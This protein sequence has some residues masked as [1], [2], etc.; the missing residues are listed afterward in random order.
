MKKTLFALALGC[1][2]MLVAKDIPVGLKNAKIGAPTLPGWILNRSGKAADYGKGEIIAGSKA[3]EK[4]FKITAPANLRA[5]FYTASP[6]SVKVGQVL[7]ISAKAKGKGTIIFGF[8]GYN[9]GS[10]F[11]GGIADASKSFQ[12]TEEMTELKAEIIVNKS[13]QGELN[14]LRPAITV[15][16]GGEAVLEDIEIEIEDKD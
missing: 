8:Y 13:T 11:L 3:G 1:A 15:M 4:A 10:K 2:A 16:K 14:T 9:N 6:F 7:K 5:A 12:L